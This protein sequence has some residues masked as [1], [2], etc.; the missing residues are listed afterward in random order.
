M[1]PHK[2]TAKAMG[3]DNN[4]VLQKAP[5]MNKRESPG[6]KGMKT[7][8]VSIKRIKKTMP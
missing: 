7:R 8:P 3:V 5:I 4:P 2:Q 1:A 6:K